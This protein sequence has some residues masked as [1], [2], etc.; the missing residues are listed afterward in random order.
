MSTASASR[1]LAREGAVSADLRRRILAAAERL[2]YT[3]NLA[4]RSLAGRRSGLI[5]IMV[6]TLA[7][8]LVAEVIAALE[9]RLA[10]AGFGVAIATSRDSP[11]ES[12]RAMRQLI[13]L[14]VEA[15]ALAEPAHGAELANVLRARGLPWVGLG[16]G[17][18]RAGLVIDGGRRRGAEL[19]CRYLLSLGHCRIGVLAPT[20]A[21]AAGVIDALGGSQAAAAA[22]GP[23]EVRD[24]N[25]AEAAMQELLDGDASPTA[26]ICGNDLHGLAAVRACL[27]R[28]IVVPRAVSVIG[29]GDADFARRA[30]PALTTV[31]VAGAALAEQLA[32]GLLGYLEHGTPPP[33]VETPLKLILRES[34][35][36]APDSRR[37]EGGFT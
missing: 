5:G 14:G 37:P 27:R 8:P 3:P 10:Q 29:F 18:D 2:G 24:A 23:R 20:A 25:A 17:L 34:T 19:A 4:A 1:A 12:V 13:G 31:R 7:E 28:G 22:H 26:V 35:A 6:N 15:V 32:N 33:A 30:V 16:D 21:T 36:Q 11:G 9:R